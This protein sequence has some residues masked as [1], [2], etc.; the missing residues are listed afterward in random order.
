M[1]FVT[2]S[3]ISIV[4]LIRQLLRLCAQRS[5]Q[6]HP[7]QSGFGALRLR[8]IPP[9]SWRHRAWRHGVYGL[10]DR[11]M[12]F[13]FVALWQLAAVDFMVSTIVMITGSLSGQRA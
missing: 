13:A 5:I 4:A 10:D 2:G 3:R 1:A 6:S 8:C 11:A 7:M 9:I 12:S